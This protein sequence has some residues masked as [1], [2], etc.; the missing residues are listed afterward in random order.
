MP[1]RSYVSLLTLVLLAATALAA[2]PAVRAQAPVAI[3]NSPAGTLLKQWLDAFN[4][5]DSAGLDAFDTAH[6]PRVNAASAQNQLRL[7]RAS[8]GLELVRVLS[9]EPSHII[10]AARAKSGGTELRGSMEVMDGDPSQIKTFW[11]QRAPLG[12]PLEGCATYTLPSTHGTSAADV[13]SED[14]IIA[15]LYD[16]ISGP[17]CQRRDWDRMRG[18]YAPGGRAIPTVTTGD[19][20]LGIRAETP[21][22]YAAAV[23]GSMEEFGFFENEVSHVGESFNGVVHRFSTYESRRGAT[24]ATP[25]ARGINSFQLLNDGKRWWVVTVYWA[26][27]RPDAMIP[28][29]YLKRP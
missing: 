26:G 7:A 19:G 8:G 25:F 2:P 20:T 23:K 22:E 24:D 15:A 17:A 28:D 27:E 21:D 11:V 16:V 18:L 29:I 14:A 1:H 5:A 9:A 6:N 4:R 13:A 12:A 10:F 3:P